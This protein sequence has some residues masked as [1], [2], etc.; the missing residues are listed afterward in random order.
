MVN[1]VEFGSLF[2]GILYLGLY[3]SVSSLAV[4][5]SGCI[6]VCSG[7]VL[8]WLYQYLS[9]LALAVFCSGC[10]CISLCLLWL[11]FALAVSVYLCVRSGC[12]L[13]WLYLYLSVFPACSRLINSGAFWLLVSV[14]E[15][16]F[17]FIVFLFACYELL[18]NF[19]IMF[20]SIY[21]DCSYGLYSQ[22]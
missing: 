7:C 21:F 19:H 15:H 18:C 12:V 1:S 4:F 6:C 11:C 22:R 10:I 2:Q 3:V 17:T 8:L 16:A 20:C 9:V 14:D 5:C 13:L